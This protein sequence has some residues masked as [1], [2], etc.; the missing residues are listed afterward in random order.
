MEKKCLISKGHI[1]KYI[2]F[3]LLA[4][5]CKCFVSIMVYKFEKYAKFNDNPL[6]IGFNAGIGMSLSII[7]LIIIKRKS[8]SHEDYKIR[9]TTTLTNDIKATSKCAN[10]NYLEKYDQKRLRTQK[11]LI[12]LACAFLDFLNRFLTFF[13]K[14]FIINNIWIFN[15]IFISIF[16]YFILRKK[17]YKHQYISCIIIVILGIA[18]TTIGLLKETGKIYIK[19]LLGIF[20][21]IL[22]SLSLVLAKFLMDHRS[23][24]PL[25]VTF[26]EGTFTLIVYS[27]LLGIFTNVPI[28]DENQQLEEVLNLTRYKGKKYIDHFIAAFENMGV[29][30]VFLFIL[31]AIGRLVSKLFGYIIVKHFTSSHIILVLMIGEIILVFKKDHGWHEI[32][33]FILF[34][35]ALF[36]LLIFTEI[37]EINACNLEKNTKKNIKIR[38]RMEEDDDY[39]GED[40]DTNGNIIHRTKSGISKIEIDGNEIDFLGDRRSTKTE[41]IDLNSD[42][43]EEDDTN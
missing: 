15:I 10:L 4:G 37:I 3:A 19:L 42:V 9:A 18:A 1:N 29:G 25:D 23:C 20:L 8:L 38:E 34:F 27:I 21:K 39:V 33:Q 11:F 36:M 24:S 40:Y 2:I 14:K 13:L 6:I 5:F 22:Y 16:D 32:V 35:F 41:L 26:Y 7:P 30:E 43:S 28:K 12:L 17:L 31:S